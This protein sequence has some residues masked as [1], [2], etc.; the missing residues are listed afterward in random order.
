MRDA[1]SDFRRSAVV[2][3]QIEPLFVDQ[4][5]VSATPSANPSYGDVLA[6]GSDEV[7][8]GGV[9]DFEFALFDG[10][11]D[12]SAV[13]KILHIEGEVILLAGRGQGGP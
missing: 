2:R 12:R 3:L 4:D 5:V 7:L 8:G 1:A 13:A 9:A 11:Q 10:E 6:D